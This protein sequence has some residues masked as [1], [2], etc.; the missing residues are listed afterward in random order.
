MIFMNRYINLLVYPLNSFQVFTT[1]FTAEAVL[2]LTATSRVYFES[3]WNI[4][5]LIIVIA[6]LFDLFVEHMGMK[7]MGISVLR[8]M[9]LVSSYT[10]VTYKQCRLE[11][12]TISNYKQIFIIVDFH[13]TFITIDPLQFV[14]YIFW[15]FI[16]MKS[17]DHIIGRFLQYIYDPIFSTICDTHIHNSTIY[18]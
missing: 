7:T 17:Y 15:D 1:F 6:S 14:Q 11:L 5:D 8:G 9:R 4:F 12:S 13:S 10:V 3:G 16:Y 18:P 2:K